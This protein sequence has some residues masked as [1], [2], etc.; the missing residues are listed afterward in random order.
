MIFDPSQSIRCCPICLAAIPLRKSRTEM[1]N[2][3]G[4]LLRIS[5]PSQPGFGQGTRW[6]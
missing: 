1:E 3:L 6:A 4:S 5:P 2:F